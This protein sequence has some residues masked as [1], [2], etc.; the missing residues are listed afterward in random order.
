MKRV[1]LVLFLCFFP[2]LAGCSLKSGYPRLEQ[3]RIIQTLGVDAGDAGLRLSLA[4]AA[5][6]GNGE[7]AVCLSA[8]GPS[9]SAALERA[10]SLSTEETLF[11]G[12]IRQL[13]LGE[14]VALE[15]LLSYIGRSA[16]LRL[17]T[18]LYLLRGATAEELLS[19]AGSES[20]GVTEILDAVRAELDY[21]SQSL[22]FSAGQVLQDL[23]RQG[24][25]LL[26]VLRYGDAAE[27]TGEAEEEASEEQIRTAAFDGF[28]VLREAE[29]CDWLEPEELLPISLLRNTMG[30]QPLTI[31][32]MNGKPAALEI[33]QGSSR[34]R[35]IWR[36]DGS[37]QGLDITAKLR[38]SLLEA[39]GSPLSDAYIDDLTARL[40][41]AVSERLRG[42]LTRSKTLRADFLGLG[43]RLE[44]AAPLA[45]RRLE[46][47]FP[48][49]L[50]KLEISLTVQGRIQHDYDLQ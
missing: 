7:D 50:G 34:V 39:P 27:N 43:P 22:G 13:V 38:A 23:Q 41:A 30:V 2:L 6:G 37:L 14:D 49:L 15:P 4:T 5:G 40:E 42:L 24:S 46:T 29:I 26:C 31:Q 19:G 10:E 8:D 11:C 47:P 16:D 44:Q 45:W 36:E 25:T 33:R 9:F 17:D 12:H 35:P 18:P 21:R 20:R 1:G 48:E 28:A 3:L 32:D